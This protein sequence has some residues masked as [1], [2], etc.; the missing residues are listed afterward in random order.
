MSGELRSILDERDI[1]LLADLLEGAVP[2]CGGS[3]AYFARRV[4]LGFVDP[5][6]LRALV[7]GRESASD[8]LEAWSRARAGTPGRARFETLRAWAWEASLCDPAW[9][10]NVD[11]AGW[12]RFGYRG[13]PKTSAPSEPG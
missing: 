1:E 2:G 5:A 12:E 4:E 7:S 6:D 10:G 3:L 13:G 11:R 9:G 8:R